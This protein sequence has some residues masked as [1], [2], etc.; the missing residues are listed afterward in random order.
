MNGT[1]A[2]CR[3]SLAWVE[4]VLDELESGSLNWDTQALLAARPGVKG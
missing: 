2:A 1:L 4:S 3:A